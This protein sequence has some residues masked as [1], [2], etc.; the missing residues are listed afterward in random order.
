M[1]FNPIID[2]VVTPVLCKT[3]VH[4]HSFEQDDDTLLNVLRALWSD[5]SLVRQLEECFAVDLQH[6][7]VFLLIVLKLKLP[8][9]LVALQHQRE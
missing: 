5:L 7:G 4:L 2:S 8:L 6:E 3:D 1:S 9:K